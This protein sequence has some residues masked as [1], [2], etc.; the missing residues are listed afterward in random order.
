M[1]RLVMLRP[2]L[3]GKQENTSINYD[4]KH[5]DMEH[6]RWQQRQSI[7]TRK[8][9]TQLLTTAILHPDIHN[10][11]KR[12]HPTLTG[13]RK[14]SSRLQRRQTTPTWKTKS[15]LSHGSATADSHADRRNRTSVGVQRSFLDDCQMAATR[16]QS[17]RNKEMTNIQM[18]MTSVKEIRRK[19]RTIFDTI[20]ILKVFRGILSPRRKYTCAMHINPLR[21][22]KKR[23][24]GT[25]RLSGFTICL[26]RE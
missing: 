10:N 25:G 26:F 21:K 20:K 3:H 19:R 13:E 24:T 1:G 5:P 6:A 15:R 8:T 4:E 7:P 18:T 22:L 2:P 14:Q 12:R 16:W 11:I 17:T 9:T 23:K